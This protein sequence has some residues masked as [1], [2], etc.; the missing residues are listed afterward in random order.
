M[1]VAADRKRLKWMLLFGIIPVGV[2]YF[3]T[4]PDSGLEQL[5]RSRDAVHHATSWTEREIWPGPGATPIRDETREIFCANG[6]KGDYKLVSTM[7][8]QTRTEMRVDGTHY[9]PEPDGRWSSEPDGNFLQ[10]CGGAPI[11]RGAKLFFDADMIIAHGSMKYLG[12]RTVGT[13]SCGDWEVTWDRVNVKEDICINSRDGLP[14]RISL[15]N[16]RITVE[17]S[18]WNAPRSF[19]API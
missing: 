13:D 18:N 17:F 4:R 8:G 11:V 2:A 1:K 15:E 10:D 19:Q 5:K 16:G 7:G 14:R 3:M 12:K 9:R 6:S